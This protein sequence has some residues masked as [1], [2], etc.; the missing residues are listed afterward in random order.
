M[1][2]VLPTQ[3][4]ACGKP[5]P[6]PELRDRSRDLA[7]CPSSQG[8]TGHWSMWHLTGVKLAEQTKEAPLGERSFQM[9]IGQLVS[10]TDFLNLYVDFCNF[11][12]INRS[13]CSSLTLASVYFS[14]RAA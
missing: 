7:V 1:I 13:K 8:V 4:V 10:E 6:Q 5:A 11:K 9:Q 2:R 12:C 14:K 3:L